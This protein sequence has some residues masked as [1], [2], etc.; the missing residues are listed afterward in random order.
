MPRIYYPG[1]DPAPDPIKGPRELRADQ[2]AAIEKIDTE[3]TA[4]GKSKA[5]LVGA[6]MGSGKTVV[7]C[8]VILRTGVKRVLIVGVQGA[9]GQ[10]RDQFED[11]Q[12]GM[13]LSARREV[14]RIDGT[15]TGQ[16]HL[17]DL[18]TGEDGIYYVGL[19]ML[20]AQDWEVVSETL[21]V[22][23]Y[24][25]AMFGKGVT[26]YVDPVKRS[27]QK[28]TYRDMPEV[29]LL[30]SDESHKHSN[31][32]SASIKTVRTIKAKGKI[33]LSGTFFGNKFENAWTIATWLWGKT[34]IG[35]KG[36][37]EATYCRKEPV[38]SKDGKK[39]I[40][41]RYGFPLSKIVGEKNPGEYVETLP[42]YVYIETPIGQPPEPEIVKYNLHPEQQ[43]QYDEMEG[44][45]LTWLRDEKGDEGAL[46]ADLPLTQRLRLRTAALGGMT[47][48]P[49][50]DEDDPDSIVFLPGS[51]SST[52]TEAYHVLHRPTWVGKKA[53]ILTHSK[54]FAIETA[55]RIGQK[56]PT[57]L[58]TGDTGKS[59][60]SDK[61]RFMLPMSDPNSIQ[62]M[63]AV[64]SAV[65]TATDGL[66]AEC[67]KVLWL[68]E[69]DNNAN[70]MQ[71]AN[72]IWRSGVL[73]EEY[74]GVKLIPR[75]TISEEIHE[76]NKSHKEQTMDSVAGSR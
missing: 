62:Y 40:T 7:S 58:K 18:V 11:Q 50:K 8:E 49:G 15:T 13:P 23:S 9:Y 12:G 17:L 20:R 34:V 14:K 35:T 30:I 33:A 37:F 46:V 69:D 47:L 19:E 25:S 43:R 53:L 59:W 10:W 21:P 67:A 73:T 55:R 4:P 44:Q 38:M 26:S 48:V 3:L 52:L 24:L 66:Q 2:L 54:Q 57:V 60:D 74:E 72:R 56:Y 6:G 65:G 28:G 61:A 1:E 31:Q 41:T 64:I 16:G 22:P 27:V 45:S 71:A 76:K 36:L 68:S 51:P 63:V 42:C 39:Q 75:G 29:D 5:V 70:N 32:K